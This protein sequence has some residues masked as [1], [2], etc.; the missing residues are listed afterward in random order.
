MAL[1]S[2]PAG[3]L[4]GGVYSSRLSRCPGEEAVKGLTTYV[5][6]GVYDPVRPV[7]ADC[8]S[9]NRF[10][11]VDSGERRRNPLEE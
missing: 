2:R 8:V 6:Q 11:N 4:A 5:I 1:L 9:S 10:A 7:T 3:P